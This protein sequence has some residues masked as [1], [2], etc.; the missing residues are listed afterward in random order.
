MRFAWLCTCVLSFAAAATT[1]FAEP[2]SQK[3]DWKLVWEDRFE[4]AELGPAWHLV[5]GR[6]SIENG[7]L[8]LTGGGATLLIDRPFAPDVRIEFTAQANPDAPPCDLSVAMS[9]NRLWGYHYL[10]AFG[11]KGNRANQIVGGPGVL[12]EN[13]PFLIEHGKTYTIQATK[14][15]PTLTMVVNG[16]RILHMTDPDPAEG[17]GFDRLGLVTWNGMY[18]DDVRVYERATPAAGRPAP[19]TAMPDLG[20][21]W[22]HRR[23]ECPPDASAA[24]RQAA[25]A[26]NRGDFAQALKILDAEPLSVET[27]ALRG[28]V[29]GDLAYEETAGD[30]QR[31]ADAAR[32]L[33]QQFKDDYRAQAFARAAQWLSGLTMANRNRKSAIRLAALGPANNPFYYKAQ[34]WQ[35]RHL[36]AAGLEGASQ[37]R[38]EQARTM[39]KELLAIWPEDVGLRELTGETV[40][41]RADLTRP[42]SDGPEWARHLQETFARHQAI[43][44][45]W[46]THR[47]FP[48]GQLGGG[49]G[50]DVEILRDWVPA[51]CISTACEPAIAGIERLVEGVWRYALRD[52]Y[53]PD[54][55][56]VEHSA[57]PSADSLPTMMLLR[58]GDPLWVERNLESA[59]TIRERFMAVNER[60]HLQFLSAEFGTDGVRREPVAGGDT[61][62][63]ARAMKHFLWLAWYGIPEARDI[64][65]QWC[66][67]WLEATMSPIGTKPAGVIPASIWFPSGGID[68]PD[69]KP[70]HDEKSHYYGFPGLPTMILESFLSAY[71]LSGEDKYLDAVQTVLDL[72][73]TGPLR[74]D[75]PGQPKDHPDN[76]LAQA[77]HQAVP[78][79]LAVYRHLT[80]DRVYDPY[81]R[82]LALTGRQMYL[83]DGKL[84]DY[85]TSFAGP[86]AALRYNWA[87]RTSEVF[88]TDRAG[89]EGAAALMG[90]YTGA[91]RDLRDA[92]TPTFAA[93]WITPDVNFAAVVTDSSPRRLR[94]WLY[95]FN[96]VPMRVGLRPWELVPGRY[97]LRQGAIV[98]GERPQV[99]RYEWVSVFSP[100]ADLE[101]R[102][103]AE[104][105]WIELPPRREWVVD[106]R[107]RAAYPQASP[108]LAD[109]A[110]H[111]RDVQREGERLKLTIHN[112]GGA[113]APPF[114]VVV[115]QGDKQVARTTVPGLPAISG[116]RPVTRQIELEVPASAAALKIAID[117]DDRVPEI[118]EENNVVGLSP[119]SLRIETK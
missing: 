109:L 51:V 67:T 59:R 49:W 31:L 42:E 32:Q 5:S 108:V 94:A 34:L 6:A 110:M 17:P 43:L 46:F 91:V 24:C 97:A 28:Y 106:L 29:L 20:Y 61:G 104:P 87:L 73:T 65:L 93:T 69:G 111:A 56:D 78:N 36:R 71:A 53:S 33:E 52:G 98:P 8:F 102:R 114:D 50:D 116:L 103:R 54:R 22:T 1:G 63:H 76:L 81:L 19:L 85:L 58:Y 14:D 68:P 82:K 84:S 30:L 88:Q 80:G 23:L 119:E 25:E 100:S 3:A 45:W 13:P 15:G 12:D 21:R 11:G 74:S 101:L 75:V 37:R 112:I 90:A 7:R 92:A 79:L 115:L 38:I 10:L 4:R 44:N 41:W 18:V 27:V 62:Y 107:L 57:E 35:A 2:G 47:Q 66:D 9:A 105:V 86:V 60:G 99:K 118:C 64:Y 89:L 113:A 16:T 72:S 48:D 26:Y 55:G 40:P 83:T 95:N 96:T 39:F 70:W 77:A 117:P